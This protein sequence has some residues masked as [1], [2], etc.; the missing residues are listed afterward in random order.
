MAKIKTIKL[1]TTTLA[2]TNS[3][4]R[5]PANA[6]NG[7]ACQT[8]KHKAVTP[9]ALRFHSNNQKITSISMSTMKVTLTVMLAS[10][11]NSLKL[12]KGPTNQI[13]NETKVKAVNANIKRTRG[14]LKNSCMVGFR[15]DLRE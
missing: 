3:N 4:G 8:N 2:H 11:R 7:D 12:N 9:I 13:T 10:G 6:T 15:I 14:N 5:T 1:M